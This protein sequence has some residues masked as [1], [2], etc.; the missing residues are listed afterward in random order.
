MKAWS[1]TANCRRAGLMPFELGL[2]IAAWISRLTESGSALNEGAK[3]ALLAP[4]G[5]E[6]PATLIGALRAGPVNS[7][8]Q[9]EVANWMIRDMLLVGVVFCVKRASV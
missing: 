9:V 2:R 1:H 8:R 5:L 3:A 6:A 4:S 7:L